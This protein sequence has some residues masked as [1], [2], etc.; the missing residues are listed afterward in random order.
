MPYPSPNRC[1]RGPASFAEESAEAAM[2]R[3][4]VLLHVSAQL[5]AGRAPAAEALRL[6]PVRGGIEY[7]DDEMVVP[8]VPRTGERFRMRALRVGREPMLLRDAKVSGRAELGDEFFRDP[9][10]L[11]AARLAD[12]CLADDDELTRVAAAALHFQVSVDPKPAI[13]TLAEGTKS[14][15]EL[16]REVAATALARV[17]PR[18]TA[19][20]RLR[21]RGPAPE[22]GART[23]TTMLIHGT[24][25]RPNEWWQ[26]GGSFHSFLGPLRPDLYGAA[27]RFEWTGGYSANARADAG[28]RLVA[29]IQ[30]H[31]EDGLG[32]IT[33]SH[34][35]NV[36]FL[37]TWG[38]PRI[39][40][41]VVLSCPVRDEYVPNF[42]QVGRLV[43]VRVKWDLVILADGGGQRFED[44]R[45]TEIVLPIWFNHSATH[46]GD[47]WT[48]RDVA[49][50]IDAA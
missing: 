3:A 21:Q 42:A 18:H 19:L 15:D 16:V 34:G 23:R 38:G 31:N 4:A 11:T 30:D 47:V 12:M 48:A 28:D 1:V 32:L 6:G 26:P 37:A 9:S 33:H 36:A 10:P 24:W 13:D 50:R 29:W 35:G 22:G 39:G 7:A 5:E 40:D 2:S 45:I 14:D 43:S 8:V 20:D 17:Y 27:D 44:P 25:A 49:A 41:L 46:D